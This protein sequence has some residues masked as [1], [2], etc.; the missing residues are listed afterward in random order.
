MECVL[1]SRSSLFLSLF[2]SP[3][4][5]AVL[6]TARSRFA[7]CLRELRQIFAKAFLHRRT[8]L[9]SFDVRS[10]FAKW[11]KRPYGASDWLVS[12]RCYRIV[13][14]CFG[15]DAR[16]Q[17][18]KCKKKVASLGVRWMYFLICGSSLHLSLLSS[19]FFSDVSSNV[20]ATATSST[21]L[22]SGSRFWL[23]HPRCHGRSHV[24]STT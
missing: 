6:N 7:K 23:Q 14:H 15:R 11:P 3:F 24:D 13:G 10:H 5:K 18:G 8:Y 19:L 20:R 4:L 17:N 16:K 21:S 22:N 2:L 1:C 12:L 9:A